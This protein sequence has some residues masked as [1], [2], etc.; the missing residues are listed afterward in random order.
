MSVV[1]DV[2]EIRWG[3][4][5]ADI[6]RIA[7]RVYRKTRNSWLFDHSDRHSAAWFGI[8][9]HLFNSVEKPTELDLV[10]AGVDRVS[11]EANANRSF[12]GV[13]PTKRETAPRFTVYWRGSGPVEDFTD[14][15][16]EREALPRLLSILST[17]HYE[18]IVTLAAYGNLAEAAKAL[19]LGYVQY[20]KRV[21][22]AREKLIAAWFSPEHAPPK[23]NGRGDTCKAGHAKDKHSYRDAQGKNVC[24]ECLRLK[25]RR[26]YWRRRGIDP[27]TG[28]I[29]MRSG[30]T[31][32]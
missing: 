2:A 32:M 7:W 28:Q 24:R 23:R 4:T 29:A 31:P 10:N 1:A 19:D 20:V 26:D 5:M 15:I 9:E 22:K 18:A 13:E 3:Y 6:D 21:M 27:G 30:K 16:A 11:S 14:R 25:S 17:D 8:T 12:Y